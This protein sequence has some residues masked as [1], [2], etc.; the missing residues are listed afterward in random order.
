MDRKKANA[1]FEEA[2]L[3]EPE[4]RVAFATEACAGDAATLAEVLSLLRAFEV[5]GEFMAGP[6]VAENQGG[7]RPL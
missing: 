1:V 5:A 3:V 7:A 6:T 2:M 4:H